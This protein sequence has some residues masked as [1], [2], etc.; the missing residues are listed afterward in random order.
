MISPRALPVCAASAMQRL[1]GTLMFVSVLLLAGMILLA[2]GTLANGSHDAQQDAVAHHLTRIQSAQTRIEK[3]L[4][5]VEDQLAVATS[6][7]ATSAAATSA[8]AASA[9]ATTAAA[10]SKS[11]ADDCPGRVPFHGLL[12]CQGSVYQQWQARIMYFHWKKQAAAAGPCG[13]MGGFTRLVA[14][15]GG[16]PDGLEGEI[17]SVFVPQL[18]ASVIESHFHF[19]VLNRPESVRQLLASPALLRQITS[20]FV[21]VLETDHVLMQPIPN[22]A[23]RTTPA[24]F[25]FGYMHAHAS[26]ERDHRRPR[27]PPP[28]SPAALV[29]AALATAAGLGD[30]ALLAG[31]LV[32]LPRPGRPLAAAHPPRPAPRHR[33]AL[34]Q[35][36]ARAAPK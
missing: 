24:A 12:T 6:A 2:H 18:P 19:G 27:H 22:L 33:A 8:A 13:D 29:T 15:E 1:L 34:A 11:D 14:S 5:D 36:S 4:H 31:G 17:P 7:A 20:D 30:P 28:S 21:L 25:T 32:R 3:K 10:A 16:K 26:Q 23:T 9:A 35:L